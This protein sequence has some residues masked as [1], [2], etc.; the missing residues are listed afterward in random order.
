MKNCS[1]WE[2]PTQKRVVEDCL[3]WERPHAG[4]GEEHKEE[5]ATE[6]MSD[7]LTLLPISL[8]LW[9]RRMERKLG[10]E[11]SPGRRKGGRKVF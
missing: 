1:P 9:Q 2:G 11:L 8:H 3:P 7:E 6:T 10:V 4:A 5:G